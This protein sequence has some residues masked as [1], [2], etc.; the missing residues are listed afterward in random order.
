MDADHFFQDFVFTF[1]KC[2]FSH[3]SYLAKTD[4]LPADTE[5]AGYPKVKLWMS[6]K[7]HDEM[8]VR[9]QIRKADAQGNRECLLIVFAA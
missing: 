4:C 7:E 1:D 8:D 6:C 3:F 2:A 5:I 9:V